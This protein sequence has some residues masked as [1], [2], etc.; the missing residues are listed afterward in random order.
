MGETHF[1]CLECSNHFLGYDTQTLW[2]QEAFMLPIGVGICNKCMM[3]GYGP[4]NQRRSWDPLWID[5]RLNETWYGCKQGEDG[6]M[7]DR[8]SEK[9]MW[10]SQGNIKWKSFVYLRAWMNTLKAKVDAGLIIHG[11][12]IPC[13]WYS[14]S[15]KGRVLGFIWCEKDGEIEVYRD[16]TEKEK[17]KYGKTKNLIK[18]KLKVNEILP[19][20]TALDTIDVSKYP[21]CCSCDDCGLAHTEVEESKVWKGR[22]FCHLCLEKDKKESRPPPYAGDINH[23]GFVKTNECGCWSCSSSDLNENIKNRCGQCYKFSTSGWID[24]KS[25]DSTWFC[26]DCWFNYFDHYK[27]VMLKEVDPSIKDESKEVHYYNGIWVPKDGS[28]VSKEQIRIVKRYHD[29]TI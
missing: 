6:Y 9:T 16:S 27:L 7:K 18:K 4:F 20:E 2:F 28:E 25:G 15:Q 11:E 17:Q 23:I 29:E 22:Y 8:P 14:T 5:E 24:R 21:K 10:P 26:R 13:A 1:C 19:P 3:Y 12:K